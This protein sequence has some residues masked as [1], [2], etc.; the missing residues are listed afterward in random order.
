MNVHSF[1]D[2]ST[3]RIFYECTFFVLELFMKQVHENYFGTQRILNATLINYFFRIIS[4]SPEIFLWC[5][6]LFVHP[7]NMIHQTLNYKQEHIIG[8]T[9]KENKEKKCEQ[10]IKKKKKTRIPNSNKWSTD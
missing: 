3:T 4:F 5:P 9:S 2:T 7:I 1:Y 10:E 6:K 8:Y